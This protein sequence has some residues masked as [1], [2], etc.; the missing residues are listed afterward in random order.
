M[1]HFKIDQRRF[2][3]EVSSLLSELNHIPNADNTNRIARA[4]GSIAAKEFVKSLNKTARSTKSEFHHLYEWKEVGKDDARLFRVKRVASAKSVEVKIL[5]KKS[6]KQVPVAKQLTTPGK[7]G[8]V[9]TRRSV[10]KNKA[11]VMESGKSI[12]WVANRN[13]VFLGNGKLIFKR[14]G[15]VFNKPY[16]GGSEVK[17]AL[18]RFTNKW[19]SGMAAG[20]IDKSKLFYKLEKDIA[21]TMSQPKIK[22]GDIKKCIR[23]TCDLYDMGSAEY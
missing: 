19:E 1:I 4:V 21:K 12:S 8:K 17:G 6:T 22:S 11:E 14:K 3:E 10:F 5:L 18:E 7:T 13:V 16:A 20:A 9:V 23:T 15:T 2:N